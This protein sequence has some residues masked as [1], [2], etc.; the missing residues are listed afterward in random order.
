MK[1][2]DFQGSL[3]RRD[4]LKTTGAIGVAS[5]AGSMSQIVY[6]QDKTILT[7]RAYSD[8]R[9]LDP[10]HSVGVVD[11]EIHS[12]IYSK[13]IQYKPGRE[14]G[15][16]TGCGRI[17]RASRRYEHCFQAETRGHVHQRLWRNDR[18]GCEV[19]V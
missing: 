19:F 9:S 11:E 5:L 14:W 18:G 16:A 3:S 8:M 17:D 10:A 1:K 12:S 4:F 15:M 13:L 2:R 7:V 6:A